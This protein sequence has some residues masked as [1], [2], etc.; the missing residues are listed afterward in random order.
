MPLHYACAVGNKNLVKRLLEYD[1]E[2]LTKDN[3][4]INDI[5]VPKGFSALAIAILFE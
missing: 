1:I 3:V 5:V 2:K 4:I